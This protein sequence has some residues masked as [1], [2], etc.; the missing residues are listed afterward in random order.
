MRRG[1][2]LVRGLEPLETRPGLVP[3]VSEQVLDSASGL[4]R[5]AGR[6]GAAVFA[7]VAGLALCVVGSL[8]VANWGGT[9]ELPPVVVEPAVADEL[10]SLWGPAPKFTSAVSLLRVP[11]LT[12]GSLFR[13]PPE[14]LSLFRVPLKASR[15]P[16]V[17]GA[18]TAA[19]E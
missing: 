18:E 17:G 19:P 4:S 1:L 3:R 16:A 7:A 11:D 8:A 9:A 15:R 12:E 6:G 2:E 13:P 14:R 5:G 10:P